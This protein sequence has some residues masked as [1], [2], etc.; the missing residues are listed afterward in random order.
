MT[1]A[2]CGTWESDP[3]HFRRPGRR[4]FLYAGWLGGLGLTLGDFFRLQAAEP[5]KE[6]KARSVINIYLQGGFA[7]MDSFDPK[8]DAPIEYRGELEAIQT[9]IPGV[10]FSQHLKKTAEIADKLTIVRSM[11]HTE[12]D[13][14]RGQHS[15]FTGYKPSPALAYPSFGSVVSEEFGPRN[16]LP[17]YICVPTQPTQFA[18]NGYLSNAYGPFA[19]GSDPGRGG[20]GG[21]G[22]SDGFTVRDLSLPSGVSEERFAS[23]KEWK[24][25]VDEHFSKLEKDDGLSAMDEFY[26]RAYALLGSLTA[27]DA[28]DIKKEPKEV[29]DLYSVGV[30]SDAAPGQFGFGRGGTSGTRF[31]LARRLVEAGARFVTVPFG[32]WDTHAYHYRSIEYQ[33]KD[34]DGGFAG[35]IRDLDERGLLDTT[36]VLV[37]SE[38]GRT[39]KI[40]SGLGRDHWP[41]VFSIIMAGGGMKR[42]YVHGASDA[43]AAEPAKS[44]LSI[45]DY[46]MTIYHLLGIDG[47]KTLMT[48]GGR[49]QRLVDCGKV[50]KEM[51][52]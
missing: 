46:A 25:L 42:G 37:T 50:V 27:R 33:M 2:K 7:H 21:M 12:V 47:R 13:H 19:L 14:G 22:R 39:P 4:E 17:P 15:M 31:M 38:F 24:Q 48:A 51:L 3:S 35:L 1:R 28:F 18:G 32:A 8:P 45:D 40:N 34:F 9:K 11:T 41:R 6:G 20:G 52:A 5:A 16:N 44:A 49:P 43:L 26:Q 23:R 10:R 29:R 30:K 36:L